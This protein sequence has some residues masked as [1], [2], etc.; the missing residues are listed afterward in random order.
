M[1][2]RMP[3]VLLPALLAVASVTA[4]CS[5]E[6][7]PPRDARAEA[8]VSAAQR[9]QGRWL[10]QS[11]QSAAPLEFALQALLNAQIGQLVVDVNGM[12]MSIRGPGVAVQRTYRI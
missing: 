10:L 11:F 5:R 9:L 6:K 4:S 2:R 7:G 8:A 12:N 1:L 3:R